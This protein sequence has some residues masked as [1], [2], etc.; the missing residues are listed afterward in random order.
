MFFIF[1]IT[2]HF[3]IT[4]NF[5]IAFNFLIITNNF[6]NLCNNLLYTIFN[7]LTR[8]LVDFIGFYV[9]S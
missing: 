9:T 5:L 1:N 8:Q 4:F 7:I 2:F 6:I 3:L